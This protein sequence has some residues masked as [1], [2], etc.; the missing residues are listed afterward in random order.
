MECEVVEVVDE[1]EVDQEVVEDL[2]GDSL[3]TLIFK[4]TVLLY[5]S[6]NIEHLSNISV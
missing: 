1:E 3:I 4:L 5:T 6:Y 2:Q